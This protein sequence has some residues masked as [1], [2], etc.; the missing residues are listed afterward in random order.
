MTL[1]F[2]TKGLQFLL[3][4]MPKTR[5]PIPTLGNKVQPGSSPS[6]RQNEMAKLLAIGLN[7]LV[8]QTRMAAS[9][10]FAESTSWPVSHSCWGKGK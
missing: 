4:P 7:C 10:L 9:E 2:V 1:P 3:V 5:V 8:F 6:W